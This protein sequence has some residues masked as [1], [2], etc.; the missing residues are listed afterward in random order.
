[1]SDEKSTAKEISEALSGL[2]VLG[3]II[4]FGWGYLFPGND[5]DQSSV[6]D[7][8]PGELIAAHSELTLKGYAD[9]VAEERSALVA[10]LSEQAGLPEDIQAQM[11]NCVGDYAYTKASDLDLSEIHQWCQAE[12]ERGDDAFGDHFNELAADDLSSH[13]SVM[14]QE[15]V[16]SKLMS[17]SSADFP[18]LPDQLIRRP[19]QTFFIRSHVDADNAF[20]ASI[21]LTYI[22]ELQHDLEGNPYDIS[23]WNF[24]VVEVHTP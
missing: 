7:K 20:G 16:K 6:S 13:A 18:W 5:N 23:S 14:C 15:Q 11:V 22:C 4:W 3:V 19:R 9:L 2:T 8:P 17:P 1:M 21:R 24:E 12:Y 10:A